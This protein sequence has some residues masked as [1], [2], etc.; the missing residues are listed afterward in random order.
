MKKLNKFE[1]YIL[2][3]GLHMWREAVEKNILEAEA[4]GK[5]SV[6]SIHYPAIVV[7]DTIDKLDSFTSKR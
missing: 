5:R 1:R 4:A 7:K 2:Q 3:E 6:F